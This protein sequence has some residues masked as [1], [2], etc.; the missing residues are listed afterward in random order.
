MIC[1]RCKR[2]LP[3]RHHQIVV[4]QMEGDECQSVPKL[5]RLCSECMM[6]S[7]LLWLLGEEKD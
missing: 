7:G 5:R 2:E 3:H 6:Q 4:A 1:D